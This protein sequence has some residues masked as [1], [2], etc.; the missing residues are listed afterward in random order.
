MRQGKVLMLGLAGCILTGAGIGFTM[1]YFSGQEKAVSKELA[2]QVQL[3]IR[4]LD[5]GAEYTEDCVTGILPGET[6]ARKPAV[7]LDG[8]SPDAYLRVKLTFGGVLGSSVDE[9]EEERKERTDRIRELEEGIGFCGGWLEGDDGFYYYQKKAAHGSIIPVYDHITIPGNWD[10]EI[11]E[12]TFTI[13]L[14]A[15]AVR[16]DC[17]EPWLE[18]SGDGI[19]SWD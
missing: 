15:E 1:L 18:A 5:S 13:E 14:Y 17:L 11:A 3:E 2:G 8:E 12:K 4:M 6:I 19:L 9:N 16:A 10:N 7:I